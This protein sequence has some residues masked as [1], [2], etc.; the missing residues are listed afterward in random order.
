MRKLGDPSDRVWPELDNDSAK[1]LR[2]LGTEVVMISEPEDILKADQLQSAVGDIIERAGVSK[3]R[4][5][6]NE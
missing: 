1:L 2:E 5:K 3:R 6:N 4:V